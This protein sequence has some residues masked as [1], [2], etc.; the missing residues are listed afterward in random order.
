MIIAGKKYIDGGLSDP[1]P[2]KQVYDWGYRNIV[3]L[4]THTK[5]I[6]P[7]WKIESL[8]APLFYRDNPKLQKLVIRNEIVSI[9]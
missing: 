7:D 3:L 8:Y 9:P 1:L 2:V 5:N 4:R 6:K